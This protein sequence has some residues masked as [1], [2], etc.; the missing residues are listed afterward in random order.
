MR[1]STQK[2]GAIISGHVISNLGFADDT[3]VLEESEAGR[4]RL[5]SN[6]HR[7]RGYKIWTENK[8]LEDEGAED[9]GLPVTTDR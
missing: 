2:K 8:H 5:M 4:Q 9:R 1:R 6:I 3:A 7:E